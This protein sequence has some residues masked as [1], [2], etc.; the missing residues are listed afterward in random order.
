MGRDV[1]DWRKEHDINEG[2]ISPITYMQ[3]NL[4]TSN[5]LGLVD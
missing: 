1:Q 2:T 5:H 3:I 4:L